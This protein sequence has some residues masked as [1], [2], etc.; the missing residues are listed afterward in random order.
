MSWKD[1]LFAGGAGGATAAVADLLVNGGDLL[2]WLVSVLI[3][4]G[5]LVYLLLSRLARL[6]PEIEWLPA[7]A[8]RRAM[9]AVSLILVGVALAKLLSRFATAWKQRNDS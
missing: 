8:I 7:A 4:Q 1:G 3:D 9:L 5:P 6:A 2:F